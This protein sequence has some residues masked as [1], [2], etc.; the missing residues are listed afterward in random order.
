MAPFWI[1]EHTD[2]NED[3]EI[4]AVL[5]MF[6]QQV[7]VGQRSIYTIDDKVSSTLFIKPYFT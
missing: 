7:S 1:Y 3:K 4:S 5:V 2:D 6:T